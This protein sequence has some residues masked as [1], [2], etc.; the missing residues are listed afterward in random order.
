MAVG[1]AISL[2]CSGLIEGFVTPSGLP[3]WAKI[4][5]GALALAAFLAYMLVL[6]RRAV[7][8]GESGDL[9]DADAVTRLVA[10]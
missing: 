3:V 5:I 6:G 8:A 2:F 10:G 1:T 7:R 9:E 4:A